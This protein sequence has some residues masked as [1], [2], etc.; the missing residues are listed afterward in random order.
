MRRKTKRSPTHATWGESS[1]QDARYWPD[2]RG[3]QS[4]A[5]NHMPRGGAQATLSLVMPDAAF[6]TAFSGGSGAALTIKN[7]FNGWSIIIYDHD[8]EYSFSCREIWPFL[9][10]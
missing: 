9:C 1:P 4:L 3:V 5:Q 2:R 8:Q 10:I 7:R 6:Q